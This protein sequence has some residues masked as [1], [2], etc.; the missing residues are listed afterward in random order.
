MKYMILNNSLVKLA[1]LKLAKSIALNRTIVEQTLKW[2]IREMTEWSILN[3]RATPT[4]NNQETYI[5]GRNVHFG[6]DGS[7]IRT[8]ISSSMMIYS[9]RDEQKSRFSIWKFPRGEIALTRKQS[10][11]RWILDPRICISHIR[12]LIDK[13]WTRYEIRFAFISEFKKSWGRFM[14]GNT[15][16]ALSFFR[17]K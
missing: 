16:K 15:I 12:L 4:P 17:W 14:H 7:S 5:I 8:F 2:I 3:N 6:I 9:S 11:T 10:K 13:D 1:L